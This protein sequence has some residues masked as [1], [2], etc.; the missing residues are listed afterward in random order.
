[1][2]LFDG[3]KK[4]FSGD[5]NG[6]YEEGIIPNI[7]KGMTG[8]TSAD[9]N[10]QA[11]NE[12]NARMQEQATQANLQI[13]QD[14]NETNRNIAEQN[15]GFQ[16]EL[17]EYNKAL[18]QQIFEREDTSYQRTAQDMLAAGLNPL[19]MQGTNGAGEVVSQTP[20]NNDYQAQVGSPI[21]ASRD[22]VAPTMGNL[23]QI[24]SA[25]GSVSS[26]INGTM[27]GS[28]ERDS[29]A[30]DNDKKFLDNLAQAHELGID[31]TQ[32]F[33]GTKM[34]WRK[35]TKAGKSQTFS[36]S[37]G[38][39]LRNKSQWKSSA[40]SGY[41]DGANKNRELTHKMSSNIY[42]TDTDFE[43]ILTAIS[44]WINNGRGEAEWKKL[45]ETFPILKLG[46]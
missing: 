6:Y 42:D 8:Q 14:T 7:W 46:R 2:G 17:Q 23:G 44:D 13:A 34:G 26:A 19:D 22:E 1:M 5:W 24:V 37:D 3:V 10:T 40:Y 30:L 45:Q 38:I 27:S 15:L 11:T 28:L 29:I 35:M 39:D 20:L 16:R 4:L 32:L 36:D 12:A 31:Y 18:Q 41:V 43:R 21:Q 25:L 33:S 9:R